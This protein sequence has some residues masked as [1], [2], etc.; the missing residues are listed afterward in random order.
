MRKG[1]YIDRLYVPITFC[2]ELVELRLLV[3]GDVVVV[4]V[5]AAVGGGGFPLTVA[6]LAAG[7]VLVVRIIL[8]N[9]ILLEF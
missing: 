6:L 4:V 2:L 8:K 3:S 5:A 1:D 9:V 7:T